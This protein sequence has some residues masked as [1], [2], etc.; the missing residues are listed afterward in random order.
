MRV[1]ILIG[2]CG[3]DTWRDLA[4]SRAYPSAAGQAAHEVLI[5]HE[6]D[7]SV[8]EIRNALGAQASGDWLC[9]LDADDELAPGFVAAMETVSDRERHKGHVLYQPNM[10]RVIRG[11][12]KVARFSNRGRTLRDSNYLP[13]GT[14][15]ARDLFLQVGG[16]G[17]FPWGFEDWSLWAKCWKAGAEVVYVPGALYI[18]HVNQNSELRKL[19]SDRRWQHTTHHEVRRELFP[20]LYQDA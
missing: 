8:V 1:S 11:R 16:F 10:A 14:L 20:E 7:A 12:R 18:A 17:D 9:F 19:W 3:S 15:V 5:E 2:T 4:W 6:P 13:I